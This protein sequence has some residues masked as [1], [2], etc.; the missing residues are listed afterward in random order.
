MLLTVLK[1]D[2]GLARLQMYACSRVTNVALYAV[3]R[4]TSQYMQ[5]RYVDE[6]SLQHPD[7]DLLLPVSVSP[8]QWVM[9]SPSLPK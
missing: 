8:V 5:H 9:N 1:Q 7:Y 3:K 4:Q 6:S 2:A